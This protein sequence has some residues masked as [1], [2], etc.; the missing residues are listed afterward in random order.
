MVITLGF[1]AEHWLQN[2]ADLPSLTS[3]STRHVGYASLQRIGYESDGGS[4]T[5]LL[6][7]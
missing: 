2:D 5:L 7:E 6:S 4:I 3:S 1:I